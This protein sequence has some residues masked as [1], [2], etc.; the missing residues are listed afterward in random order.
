MRHNAPV[1]LTSE[2]KR[3]ESGVSRFLN[4]HLSDISAVLSAYRARLGNFA[5]PVRPDDARPSYR[6]LGHTIDHRLRI[7]LGAETGQPIETGV[8][9]SLV[10][11]NGFPAAEVRRALHKAGLAMLDELRHY[12]G[13]SGPSLVL[14]PETEDRLV[15]LCFIASHFEEFFRLGGFV[16]GSWL[17]D[18]SPATTL[19]DLIAAVPDYVVTDIAAQMALAE[20]PGPFSSWC[21]L[22]EEEKICGPVF[23]GSRDVGGADA[24]FI[25]GRQLIDCK[26]TIRPERLG[27]AEIHQLAGYLL[28]DYED[29]YGVDRVAFY[30]SRQGALIS[31]SAEDFLGLLGSQLA[32]PDLRA[33]C[34]HALTNGASGNPPPPVDERKPL[35]HPR[36][37][38]PTQGSLFDAL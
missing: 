17:G 2:L 26:A 34:Q 13:A 12:E 33:A 8:R 7:C 11:D 19:E 24:D 36:N 3:P 20:R 18:A 28:L 23:G 6:M 21:A 35:P 25:L 1:S 32:L 15:R 22:P 38:P 29:V 14:A 31:W 5:P 4:E 30:L 37:R 9:M 27:R 10:A 16:R